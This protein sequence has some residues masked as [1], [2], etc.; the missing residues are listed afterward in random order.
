MTFFNDLKRWGSGIPAATV[1]PAGVPEY[2]VRADN[3]RPNELARLKRINSAKAK[4]LDEADF[5]AARAREAPQAPAKPG[6]APVNK[7][8]KKTDTAPL[9]IK[10]NNSS[11][12]SV[13]MEDNEG[14]LVIAY[15]VANTNNQPPLSEVIL[16]LVY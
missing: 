9:P 5:A 14:G 7:T 10:Q 13:I 16:L 12:N 6:V 8:V 11:N 15:N 2:K 1:W 3:E 4:A